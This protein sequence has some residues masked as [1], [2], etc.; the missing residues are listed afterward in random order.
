MTARNIHRKFKIS[1][2][3]I[4][5]LPEYIHFRPSEADEKML[6]EIGWIEPDAP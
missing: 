3:G 6:K 4:L 5:K 1:D 2:L